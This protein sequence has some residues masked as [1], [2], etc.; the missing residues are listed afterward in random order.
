MAVINAVA[1]RRNVPYGAQDSRSLRIGA[2]ANTWPARTTVAT[3]GEC[4]PLVAKDPIDIAKDAGTSFATGALPISG[5]SGGPTTTV[6][7]T[8]RS[9]AKDVLASSDFNYND[10][11]LARCSQFD[12][13][14]TEGSNASTYTVRLLP[15]PTIGERSFAAVQTTKPRGPGDLG[16]ATLNVLAGTLSLALSLSVTPDGDMQPAVESMAGIAR[17]LLDEA[18]TNPPAVSTPTPNSRTPEQLAALIQGIPGPDGSTALVHAQLIPA[19]AAASAPPS[20]TA[21]TLDDAA[22]LGALGGSSMVQGTYSGSPAKKS[23][24]TLRAVSMAGSIATPYPFDTRAE[25]LRTCSSITEKVLGGS[26]GRAWSSLRPLTAVPGGDA[27]YAVV[28]EFSDGTGQKHLAVGARRGSLT[29]EV[30]DVRATE[31]EVQPAAEALAAF[32]NQIFAKSGL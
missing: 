14:H 31:A 7:F 18:A 15:A 11:L 16:G 24:L 20:Q 27:S 2:T 30:D 29:I 22:Y 17:D 23:F 9:A 32:V 10:D 5:R 4:Q 13:Q 21:C 3:P 26:Q 25:A 19:E 6:M 12:L 1:A 8:I 28:Y